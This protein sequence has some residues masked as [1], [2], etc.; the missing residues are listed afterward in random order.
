M[1]P[2]IEILPYPA[3]QLSSVHC[4]FFVVFLTENGAH[5]ETPAKT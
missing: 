5:R 4:S 2:L 3:L 1:I